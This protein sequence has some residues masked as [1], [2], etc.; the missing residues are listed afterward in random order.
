VQSAAS[1][2]EEKKSKPRR[3]HPYDPT[4]D[5]IR[6]RDI[7]A[8]TGLHPAT[9]WRW[10]QVGL[11]PEPIRLGVQAVGWR[12]ADINAWLDA[13]ARVGHDVDGTR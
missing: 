8:A 4:A 12:R 10:R 11:F 6:A 3:R 2:N 13:R 1:A 5:I 9:I 7:R